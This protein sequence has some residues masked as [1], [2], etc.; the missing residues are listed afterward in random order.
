MTKEGKEKI[1][2]YLTIV[3]QLGM[4]P[5]HGLVATP[6]SKTP[7]KTKCLEYNPRINL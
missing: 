5:F 4:V 7:E 3:L 1:E 2:L 6:S